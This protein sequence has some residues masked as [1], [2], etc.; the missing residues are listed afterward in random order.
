MGYI[1]TVPCLRSFRLS[2]SEMKKKLDK[3][4]LFGCVIL[5]YVYIF[6]KGGSEDLLCV[7]GEGWGL[8]H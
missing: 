8:C 2:L 3:A 1:L 6:C 7:G 4:T 5:L